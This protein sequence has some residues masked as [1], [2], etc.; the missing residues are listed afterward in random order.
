M[1]IIDLTVPVNENT[2]VYPGDPEVVIKCAGMFDKDGYNDH[3]ISIGTHVGTHID[4]PFHMLADGKKLDQA[5]I[6][7]FVGRGCYINTQEGFDL[8]NVKKADIRE[9]DIVLFHTGIISRYH[10][11]SYYQDYPE[12]PEDIAR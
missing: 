3:L 7:Q 2:P 5:P 9:G 10:E 12:I 1:T 11:T 8:K 6:E 4:A